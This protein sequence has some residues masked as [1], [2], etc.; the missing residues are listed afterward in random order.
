MDRFFLDHGLVVV[1]VSILYSAM[2]ESPSKL[3]DPIGIHIV[4][5][6]IRMLQLWIRH[7]NVVEFLYINHMLVSLNDLIILILDHNRPSVE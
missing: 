3:V 2:A 5:Y 1:S 4:I 7:L 6:R